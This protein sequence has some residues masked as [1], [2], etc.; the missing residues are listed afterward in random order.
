MIK[1]QFLFVY[2]SAFVHVSWKNLQL[3]MYA[4]EHR[5]VKLENEKSH[6]GNNLHHN[7]NSCKK[8]AYIFTFCILSE[9]TFVKLLDL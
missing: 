5:I 4:V 8:N 1:V 3:H 2:L 9:I 6:M 7:W